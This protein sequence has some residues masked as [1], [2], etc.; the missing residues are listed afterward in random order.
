[1]LF[2][3]SLFMENAAGTIARIAV[4][5]GASGI[6]APGNRPD[7]VSALRKIVGTEKTVI[8]CGMGFQGG[9]TGSALRAGADFELYGRSIY[10]AQDPREAAKQI[11]IALRRADLSADLN[12]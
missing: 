5:A 10:E 6:Q 9:E 2:R 4:D 3:S 12:T 1:M 11:S 8:A 7:R